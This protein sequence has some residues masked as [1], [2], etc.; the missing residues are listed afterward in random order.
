[1]AQP[2]L[3][4]LATPITRPRLP[5]RSMAIMAVSY[6]GTGHPGDTNEQLV[7][8]EQARPLREGGKAS[9]PPSHDATKGGKSLSLLSAPPRKGE[10]L[11]PFFQARAA[12][13]ESPFPSLSRAGGSRESRFPCFSGDGERGKASFPP[14]RASCKEG[15][16][17][18]LLS[19][20]RG[21]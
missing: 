19:G 16:L 3:R 14:S 18:S 17:R 8:L 2:R 7:A 15:K 1:M 11:F 13:G 21:K 20:N 9:F 4:P 5:L 10:S 6:P 12:N